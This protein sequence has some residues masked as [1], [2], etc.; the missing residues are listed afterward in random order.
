MK[1]LRLIQSE[2]PFG[3]YKMSGIGREHGAEAIHEYTQAKSIT[4]G[5][6]R[7]KSRFEV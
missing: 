3:G 4:V 1:S 2:I 7:F 5:L 6:E